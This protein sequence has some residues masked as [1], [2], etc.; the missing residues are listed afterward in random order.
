MGEIPPND[1]LALQYMV[2]EVKY[3]E[4]IPSF[5]AANKPAL[6]HVRRPDASPPFC[7]PPPR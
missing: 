6:L 7:P 5:F 4:E 1:K 2:D 3:V